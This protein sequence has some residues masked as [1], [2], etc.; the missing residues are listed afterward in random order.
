MDYKKWK[1][2]LKKVIENNKKTIFF[3]FIFIIVFFSVFFIILFSIIAYS[4]SKMVYICIKDNI[5]IIKEDNQFNR[6]YFLEKDKLSFINMK[7]ELTFKKGIQQHIQYNNET[8]VINKHHYGYTK[9]SMM[10]AILIRRPPRGYPNLPGPEDPRAIAYKDNLFIFYNDF[11]DN[12][13]GMFL[14]K[15]NEKKDLL[16]V[17]E[18]EKEIEKNWSPFIYKD[19]FYCSYSINPHIV[20]KINT[21]T[22]YC[23]E[24]YHHPKI[25]T[26]TL[27]GGTSAIYIQKYNVYLAL[28]HSKQKHMTGF[29]FDYFCQ[30]YLFEAEPPF[31]IKKISK[32]FRFLPNRFL[33]QIRDY[34][35]E[36]P[37]GLYEKDNSLFISVGYND[38]KTYLLEV[39]TEWFFTT[40]LL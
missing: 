14:Y 36:F 9:F 40:F 33:H 39:N 4:R 11:F 38:S 18:K 30:A 28:A 5:K 35:V 12:R 2:K 23:N 20:L 32:T 31:A 16:L 21:E 10:N 34:N 26:N 8:I 3:G 1:N 25:G 13:V 15:Y 27:F 37:I 24:V 6:C 7:R 19:E 17:Y 22:G 29:I